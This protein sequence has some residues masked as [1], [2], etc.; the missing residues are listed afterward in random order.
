MSTAEKVSQK[1]ITDARRSVHHTSFL[2]ALV[3][4]WV[5]SITHR[6]VAATGAGLP[7]GEMFPIRPYRARRSGVPGKS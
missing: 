1:V 3:Q 5:G 7:L 6:P 4:A 2:W